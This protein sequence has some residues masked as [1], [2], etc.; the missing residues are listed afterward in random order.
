MQH[1]H[2][3]K[4]NLIF[5]TKKH[6]FNGCPHAHG[7]H[8]Q[9]FDKLPLKMTQRSNG[10]AK[11]GVLMTTGIQHKEWPLNDKQTAQVVKRSLRCQIIQTWHEPLKLAALPTALAAKSSRMSSKASAWRAQSWSLPKSPAVNQPRKTCQ[12]NMLSKFGCLSVYDCWCGGVKGAKKK[13]QGTSQEKRWVEHAE[14][15]VTTDGFILKKRFWTKRKRPPQ[16]QAP[17][18]RRLWLCLLEAAHSVQQ[19][20]HPSLQSS[21]LQR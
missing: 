21:H 12:Q 9:T 18:K 4:S 3:F 7:A 16:I 5:F 14:M 10:I 11:H 13:M 17:P 8:C 15:E 6:S 1:Q 19:K 2:N 20:R